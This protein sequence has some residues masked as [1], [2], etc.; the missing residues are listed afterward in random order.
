MLGLGTYHCNF[1]DVTEENLLTFTY[2]FMY[3]VLY[4]R[5]SISRGGILIENNK[6]SVYYGE[7][8]RGLP[9]KKLKFLCLDIFCF[10]A[11]LNYMKLTPPI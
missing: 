4:S 3:C 1:G 10:V 11:L 2:K 8:G 9:K 6:R 7:R 5:K